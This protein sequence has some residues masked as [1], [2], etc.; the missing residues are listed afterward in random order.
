ML[1]KIKYKLRCQKNGI[2]VTSN[3][4]KYDVVWKRLFNHEIYSVDNEKE[5]INR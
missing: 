3:P 5:D 1:D 4:N 2:L